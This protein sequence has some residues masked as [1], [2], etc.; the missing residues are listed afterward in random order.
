MKKIGN[1]LLIVIAGLTLLGVNSIVL[2]Q[3]SMKQ[4]S[5]NASAN[6]DYSLPYPGILP[7]HSLY[8]LKMA[9]DKILEMLISD[10]LKKTD[11]YLLMADK[12]MNSALY[13]LDNNKEK[14]AL[15]TATKGQ[16]YFHLGLEIIEKE[17]KDT[18][19]KEIKDKY[20][21][22]VIKHKMVLDT[23]LKKSSPALKTEVRNAGENNKQAIARINKLVN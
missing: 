5:S 21:R 7:D 3:K 22:A 6:T 23:I 1:S 20:K 4:A 16:N 17:N 10:P 11:F 8:N 12:R 18:R 2:A 14:L 13:L 9:R 19:Y 15:Q